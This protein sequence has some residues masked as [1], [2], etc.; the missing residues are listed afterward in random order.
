[1]H[2]FRLRVYNLLIEIGFCPIQNTPQKGLSLPWKF[3]GQ[4]GLPNKGALKMHL[5]N[6]IIKGEKQI[7]FKKQTIFEF[8]FSHSPYRFFPPALLKTYGWVAD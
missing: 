2:K 6:L 7:V 1:M 5:A 8:W 4:V 3:G